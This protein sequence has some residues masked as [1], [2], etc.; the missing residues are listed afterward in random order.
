MHL[1]LNKEDKAEAIFR[2]K[3]IPDNIEGQQMK[4][5]KMTEK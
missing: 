4:N 2:I 3:M 1:K 5:R